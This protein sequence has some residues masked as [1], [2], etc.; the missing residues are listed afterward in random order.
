MEK[1]EGGKQGK[2]GKWMKKNKKG[3]ETEKRIIVT[4]NVQATVICLGTA[5]SHLCCL[6]LL[7]PVHSQQG[8]A[9]RVPRFPK[10]AA[11]AGAEAKT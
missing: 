8:A 6:E 11:K 4:Q 10:E 9:A 1:N 5:K 3:G 2:I 7:P